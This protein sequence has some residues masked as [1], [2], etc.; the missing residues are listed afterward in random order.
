MGE[1]QGRMYVKDYPCDTDDMCVDDCPRYMDDC[2][3]WDDVGHVKTI[4]GKCPKCGTIYSKVWVEGS[5]WDD[6]E[7][8]ICNK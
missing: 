8:H 3:G 5:G 6:I 7:A 4:E 2:D 1:L